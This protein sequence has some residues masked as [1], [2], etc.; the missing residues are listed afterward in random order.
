VATLWNNRIRGHW[1]C[2]SQD[3][4]RTALGVFVNIRRSKTDQEG[5][6]R[7]VL[8]PI[9]SAQLC[10]VSA[11]EQWLAASG[12]AEGPVFRA[13]SRGRKVMTT[14]LSAEAVA[15][16]VKERVKSLGRDA[17]R[18]SGHSLRAGFSTSAASAGLPTWRI[19][20]QTGH[21]SDS[22]LALYIREVKT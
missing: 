20:A 3:V 17:S 1:G 2:R 22:T 21:R 9:G 13:V 11:L 10:P 15:S 6:G 16:I 5:Q 12:I 8:I 4:E 7:K 14:R 19:K 18:Y